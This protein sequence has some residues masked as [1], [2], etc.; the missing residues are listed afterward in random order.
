MGANLH[1]PQGGPGNAKANFRSEVVKVRTSEQ[2]AE[3]SFD[4][5][6]KRIGFDN[7]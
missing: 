7:L 6:A 4:V 5:V 3:D 1:V 2:D